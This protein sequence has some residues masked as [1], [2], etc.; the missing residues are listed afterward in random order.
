MVNGGQENV[1]YSTTIEHKMKPSIWNVGEKYN[2]VFTINELFLKLCISDDRV[3][4]K[5]RCEIKKS[6]HVRKKKFFFRE[7]TCFA[8]RNVIASS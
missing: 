4:T 8:K 6:V 5:W 3:G 7:A 2:T 1:Y